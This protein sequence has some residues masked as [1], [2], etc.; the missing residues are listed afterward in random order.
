MCACLFVCVCLC[1]CER[2]RDRE[3]RRQRG[4]VSMWEVACFCLYVRQARRGVVESRS[5]NQ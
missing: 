2:E 3:S 5:A 4:S 1:V